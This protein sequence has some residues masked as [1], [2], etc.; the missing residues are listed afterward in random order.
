[1]YPIACEES[2]FTTLLTSSVEIT[3]LVQTVERPVGRGESGEDGASELEATRAYL[4]RALEDLDRGVELAL[5]EEL[6]ADHRDDDKGRLVQL[7][8]LQLPVSRLQ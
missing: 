3:H 7:H 1:M 6:L 2:T 5:R 4:E 8:H